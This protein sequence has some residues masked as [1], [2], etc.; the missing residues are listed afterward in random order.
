MEQH[1]HYIRGSKVILGMY[2]Y[3]VDILLECN[4][5]T[6]K[7]QQVIRIFCLIVNVHA[8]EF[9]SARQQSKCSQTLHTKLT[10]REPH[11]SPFPVFTKHVPHRFFC[12][13]RVCSVSTSPK[14]LKKDKETVCI[15]FLRGSGE[16]FMKEYKVVSWEIKEKLRLCDKNCSCNFYIK[17]L[18]PYHQAS[19]QLHSS[20]RELNITL[21]KTDV[22]GF[23]YNKNI[24]LYF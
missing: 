23:S 7:T 1:L 5:T 17:Y 19:Q 9:F 21:S 15:D 12:Q 22:A 20:G 8:Q 10:E 2:S 18:L 3:Y 14:R 6:N 24:I 16:E 11:K 4:V 13:S